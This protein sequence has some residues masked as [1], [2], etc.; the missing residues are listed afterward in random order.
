MGSCS[1][2]LAPQGGIIQGSSSVVQ[3]DAWNW[4]DAAYKMDNGIH[5]QHAHL[6]QPPKPVCDALQASHQPAGDPIKAGTG[7]DR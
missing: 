2:V 4:E 7:T 3:L 5:L 1:P 6:Y